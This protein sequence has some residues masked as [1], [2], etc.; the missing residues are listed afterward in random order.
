VVGRCRTLRHRLPKPLE[1][2]PELA[3]EPRAEGLNGKQVSEARGCLERREVAQ[4]RDPFECRDGRGVGLV[5]RHLEHRRPIYRDGEHQPTTCNVEAGNRGGPSEGGTR[6]CHRPRCQPSIPRRERDP[7]QRV[8]GIEGGHPQYLSGRSGRKPLGVKGMPLST[9]LE[10]REEAPESGPT[11]GLREEGVDRHGVPVGDQPWR[12][13]PGRSSPSRRGF[14]QSIANPVPFPAPRGKNSA[15]DIAPNGGWHAG[16]DYRGLIAG[17][18]AAPRLAAQATSSTPAD[19]AGFVVMKNADTVAIERFERTDV[20]WKGTCAGQQEGCRRQLVDRD[21]PDGTVPL[22]EV[23]E[24]QKPPD[25][26][27]KARVISRARIIVKGDSVSVDQ[28]TPNGLVTR[29]FQSEEGVVPYL[30]L[31]FGMLEVGLRQ[32]QVA[33]QKDS[34]GL[35]VYFFNLGG[36]QTVRGTLVQNADGKAVLN[37]GEVQFDLVIAPDGRLLSAA[38]PAQGLKVERIQ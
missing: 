14:D 28:M 34:L 25:P 17:L 35:K 38:I 12:L 18:F 6:P 16:Q 19:S 2:V 13:G 20:T 3:E 24:S 7:G 15:A 10:R 5:E 4:C 32:A 29:L 11:G 22:V 9:H 33:A 31:S 30:N 36:G 27:M 37:I 21:A 23:M 1:G 8:M 26:R